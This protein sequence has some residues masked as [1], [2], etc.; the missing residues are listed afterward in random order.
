LAGLLAIA[1]LGFGH[2]APG[3]AIYRIQE[4][5]D[6]EMKLTGTSTL[7]KW[8]MNAK[9]FTGEAQFRFDSIRSDQLNS[10][11]ALNFS[12]EVENLKSNEKELDKNAYK[13]MKANEYRDIVYQL[14]WSKVVHGKGNK[15]LIEAHGNLTIAGVTRSVKMNVYCIVNKDSTITCTGSEKLKMSDY[16]I[17]PPSFMMG[18]MKTGD[19]IT[20]DFILIYKK[21]NIIDKLF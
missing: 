13:A 7:H 17:H 3:Q 18:A 11:Q 21:E 10:L 12:L 5:K 14:V 20:L 6:I 2:P 19:A 9:I 8:M 16:K 1:V 4:S 15:Y